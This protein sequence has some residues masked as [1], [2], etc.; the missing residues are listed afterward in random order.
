MSINP[1]EIYPNNK[2]LH[3]DRIDFSKVSGSLELP[4]LVEIQTD[5]Y[6][7]FLEHGIDEVF[8]EVSSLSGGEKIRLI[9][10]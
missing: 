3:N 6:K 7:W 9:F 8:K 1:N 4:N 2:R 10:A 5:S